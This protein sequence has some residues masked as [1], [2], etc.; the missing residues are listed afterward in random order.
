MSAVRDEGSHGAGQLEKFDIA[1]IT[2]S[3]LDLC[4]GHAADAP[5]GSLA[6]AGEAGLDYAAGDSQPANLRPNKIFVW[7]AGH[8]VGN[9]QQ[10]PCRWHER[11]LS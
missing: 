8:G 9:L 11:R 10:T 3:T 4:S 7:R 2:N 6:N 5:S 1:D